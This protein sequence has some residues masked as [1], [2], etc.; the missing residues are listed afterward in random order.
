MLSWRNRDNE[1]DFE[2]SEE[3]QTFIIGEQKQYDPMKEQKEEIIVIST[4]MPL[5]RTISF[6]SSVVFLVALFVRFLFDYRHLS[7]IYISLP[8]SVTFIS[9]IMYLNSAIMLQ[10][11][12]SK[13]K[14]TKGTTIASYISL[15]TGGLSMLIFICL[16]ALK[17]DRIISFGFVIVFIPLFLCG[18]MY[19]LYSIMLSPIFKSEINWLFN[20]ITSIDSI[21]IMLSSAL[22]SNKIDN[23]Y[24]YPFAYAFAPIYVCLII[25]FVFYYL[26]NHIRTGDL[27]KLFGIFIIGIGVAT[28]QLKFDLIL[29][30][31][32]HWIDIGLIAVGYYSISFEFIFG[33]FSDDIKQIEKSSLPQIK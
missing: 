31:A 29:L 30:N 17:L 7:F 15:N 21:L 25:N 22:I 3:L 8:F 16:F 18:S 33:T 2:Q 6:I 5:M 24:D 10:S 20:A 9:L 28:L 32:R 26:K 11:I 1:T 14:I 27:M 13:G 23:D 19:L 12:L 4:S